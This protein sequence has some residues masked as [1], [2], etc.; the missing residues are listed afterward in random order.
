QENVKLQQ[1]IGRGTPAWYFLN[2]LDSHLLDMVMQG[3]YA[4]IH[5]NPLALR[6]YSCVPYL[7]GA[8]PSHS[9]HKPEAYRAIKFVLLPSLNK[10]TPPDIQDYNFLRHAMIDTLNRQAVSFDFAIQF[11]TDPIN[12]PIED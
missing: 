3:L 11:Q 10:T 8:D 1:Q 7:Y 9:G 2:P 6:Y 12:M 5:A 4:R